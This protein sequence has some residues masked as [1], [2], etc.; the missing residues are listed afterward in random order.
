MCCETFV[1]LS[2]YIWAF[3]TLVYD[4]YIHK[5]MFIYMYV[6]FDGF[7]VPLV[8]WRKW[9]IVHDK[10]WR[11]KKKKNSELVAS[12]TKKN[13][14]LHKPYVWVYWH[15]GISWHA[16][17][18]SVELTWCAQIQH[19]DASVTANNCHFV[20]LPATESTLSMNVLCSLS[21]KVTLRLMIY[22]SL[23]YP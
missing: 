8:I 14:Y 16:T 10:K 13:I 6:Q 20:F 5:F 23:F 12:K 15:S 19:N 17:I 22:A 11:K 4:V 3:Y 9:A 2:V 1:C 18:W 7:N 21:V